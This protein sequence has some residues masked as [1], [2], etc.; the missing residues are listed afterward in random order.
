MQI[1]AAKAT[2]NQAKNARDRT[3]AQQALNNAKKAM[4]KLRKFQF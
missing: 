3:R 4:A 1:A 2:L